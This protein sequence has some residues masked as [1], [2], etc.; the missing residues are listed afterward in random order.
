MQ[1]GFERDSSRPE[2][3]NIITSLAAQKIMKKSYVNCIPRYAIYIK[4]S[5]IKI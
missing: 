3:G 2:L 4:C 5:I 1:N